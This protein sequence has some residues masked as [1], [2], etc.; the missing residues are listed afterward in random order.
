MASAVRVQVLDDGS[1]RLLVER[2]PQELSAFEA[3]KLAEHLLSAIQDSERI[4]E[5]IS[6]KKRAEKRSTGF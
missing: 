2:T 6:E 1:I 5:E 4:L 3:R